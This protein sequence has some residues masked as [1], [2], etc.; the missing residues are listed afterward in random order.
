MT[1]LWIAISTFEN[2][3]PH[4][5][6]DLIALEEPLDLGHRDVGLEFVVDHD[7]LGVEAAKLAA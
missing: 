6:I 7:H 1:G 2:T 4:D 5:E 3:G